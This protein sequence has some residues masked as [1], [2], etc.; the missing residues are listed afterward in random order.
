MTN[1][2][3]VQ[4]AVEYYTSQQAAEAEHE[5]DVLVAG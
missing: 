4:A 1:T 2:L 5:E 3:C